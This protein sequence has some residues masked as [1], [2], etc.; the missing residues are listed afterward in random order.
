MKAV[1]LAAGKGS[2]I[3]S[4]IRGIPKPL[5]KIAGKPVLQY[6]IE[7]CRKHGIRKLFINTHHH[8]IKIREYFGDGNDFGVSIVYSYEPKLLG[9]A[10]ALMNFHE[11]LSTGPFFV[12]YADN[13]SQFNLN[14]LKEKFNR[15]RPL[16]VIGFHFRDDVSSSG[17]ADFDSRG[18][19]TRF[20]EKPSDGQTKSRW[21]N[22]GIYYLSPKIFNHIPSGFSDFGKDIFPRLL[23]NGFALYGVRNKADVIAFDTPE[24]YRESMKRLRVARR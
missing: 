8:A 24:M 18:R 2:R 11:H 5:L 21:V 22:A 20:I 12:L 4:L 7:L 15:Y 19:I 16:A 3:S 9:T 13:F 23:E 17:V 14:A 10:G 1:L 6:N